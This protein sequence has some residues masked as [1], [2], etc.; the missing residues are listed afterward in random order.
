[1]EERPKMLRDLIALTTVRDDP[2]LAGKEPAALGAAE[3]ARLWALLAEDPMMPLEVAIP[4]LVG[5]R[6]IDVASARLRLRERNFLNEARCRTFGDIGARPAASFELWPSATP[7]LLGSVL[8][9]LIDFLDARPAASLNAVDSV[10]PAR[11]PSPPAPAEMASLVD[12][13]AGLR[14]AQD[15]PIA[16]VRLRGGTDRRPS[17]QDLA[18]EYGVTRERIRQRERQGLDWVLSRSGSGTRLGRHRDALISALGA[19]YPLDALPGKSEFED[20]TG[21]SDVD[22]GS[23]EWK[24]LLFVMG[25]SEAPGWIIA[26]PAFAPGATGLASHREPSGGV[27]GAEFDVLNALTRAG[28]RPEVSVRWLTAAADLRVFE[29]DVIVW[30]ARNLRSRARAVL[31][32]RGEPMSLDDLML[33]ITDGREATRG[34][35][36]SVLQIMTRVSMTHVALPD[37]G[38]EAYEGIAT[39]IVK[40]LTACPDKSASCDA[41]VEA[42]ISTCGAARASVNAYVAANPAIVLEDGTVRLTAQAD[43]AVMSAGASPGRDRDVFAGDA[44]GEFIWLVCVD[45][46]ILR[47]SGRPLPRGLFGELGLA[48]G[49]QRLLGWRGCEIRVSWTLGATG[50]T[51]GSLR[52]VANTLEAVEGDVLVFLLDREENVSVARVEAVAGSGDVERFVR[53]ALIATDDSERTLDLIARRSFVPDGEFAA[54]AHLAAAASIR[55]ARELFRALV[56]PVAGEA[57]MSDSSR[58]DEWHE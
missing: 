36:N 20:L 16:L 47:G 43:D 21:D 18:D 49:D 12:L 19:A 15:G 14:A 22:Q 33:V 44:P 41:L 24:L 1:M 51:V 25:Y 46:D 31:A 56:T 38:M 34:E 55:G 13:A 39:E 6:L 28:V 58:G 37:W 11:P 50:P 3:W 10:A 57:V 52:R 53:A 23:D 27:F 8:R 7:R 4:G 48:R 17:L 54:F 9:S 42:M 32:V 26:G 29:G 40:W 30:P 2:G 45:H 5:V 35:R